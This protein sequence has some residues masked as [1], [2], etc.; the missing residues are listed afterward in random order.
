MKMN[1]LLTG[2]VAILMA[3][4]LAGCATNNSAPA[5][6]V[7]HATNAKVIKNDHHKTSQPTS[8]QAVTTTTTSHAATNSQVT[9]QVPTQAQP[10]NAAQVSQATTPTSTQTVAKPQATTDENVL[11]G[12]FK[13]S[14]V[15]QQEQN[16]YI[17]TKQGNENYQIEVRNNNADNTVSHLSGLYQYNPTSGSVQQMN[18]LSGQYE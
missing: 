5:T 12:F 8:N 4:G 3:L 16:Q 18:I 10:V 13:A 1:K 15:Q 2:S 11:N 7:H 6:A 14:G 9:T 17:V